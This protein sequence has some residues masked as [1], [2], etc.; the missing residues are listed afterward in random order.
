MNL[1]IIADS[2]I[3]NDIIVGRRICGDVMQFDRLS[4]YVF[5]Y[6]FLMKGFDLLQFFPTYITL[7]KRCYTKHKSYSNLKNQNR[8]SSK[9]SRCRRRSKS[10]QIDNIYKNPSNQFQRHRERA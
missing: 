4:H 6:I 7:Y 5:R 8:L 1:Y 3:S 10:D 9:L 2:E